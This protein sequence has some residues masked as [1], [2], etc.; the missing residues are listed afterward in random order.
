MTRPLSGAEFRDVIGHFAS[1]VTIITAN[2]AGRPF[3]TTASAVSSLS[4]EPP[5][6]LACMNSTSTT[7]QAMSSAKSF[8]I[9]ILTDDQGELALRFATKDPDKF[10]G[11]ELVNGPLGLPLLAEAL[12]TL[13]CEVT[14]E[15]LAGTHK[16]F[17]AEVR[18]ATSREGSPLAY[19]RGQFGRLDLSADRHVYETLRER[20]LARELPVDRALE[21]DELAD[22]LDVPVGSLYYAMGRL[23]TEGFVRRTATGGFVVPGISYEVLEA[24]V[25]ACC[26]I[27]LG[28]LDKVI[29][30]LDEPRIEQLRIAMQ[31][32]IEHVRPGSLI[33][34]D[35]SIDANTRFHEM[36]VAFVGSEPLLAAYRRVALP[37]ILARS[38]EPRISSTETD[39]GFGEDHREI[40]DAI[41]AADGQRAREAILRHG[42]RIKDAYRAIHADADDD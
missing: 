26:T 38:F 12:A 8:A 33:D 27:E 4:L 20:L 41:V 25:D 2:D 24:A 9:N 30:R 28:V 11:I 32:T 1:G 39:L 36:I 7:G 22:G 19:F 5:M 10:R 34:V 18:S 14:S 21:L 42:E 31:A 37:G 3:G 16:V 35:T 6:V 13:E 17:I 15:V 40:V 23:S 29:D